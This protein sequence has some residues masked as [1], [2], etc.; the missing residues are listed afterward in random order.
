MTGTYRHI[1]HSL[2][3][4][5][6]PWALCAVLS[7]QGVLDAEM[8]QEPRAQCS[9]S[10]GQEFAEMDWNAA[11]DEPGRGNVLNAQPDSAIL[12]THAS[13]DVA[14]TDWQHDTAELHS[15][16]DWFDSV[17]VG[18]DDGFVIASPGQLSLQS[19]DSP[20]RMKLNG[21][22]QLRHSIFNSQGPNRDLNQIQLKRARI[23]FSG[24]AF[25]PDFS[26]F[27]QLD[28]RS[29]SGD[30]LR[31]LDY[32][33]T[34]DVGHDNWGYDKGTF[35]FKT[36]KYKMPF[37]MARHL[38]GREFEFTDRSMASIFFDVNRSLALGLYGRNDRL[39]I[40]LTWE[41]A[42]FNGL[43]TGGAET[44][45]SGTLDNNFAYSARVFCYPA[46]GDWGDASLADFA[47][48]TTPTTRFGAGCAFSTIDRLGDSEFDRVRVVDSGVTL[49]KLLP[50]TV[51][52]YSV[53]LYS[54]DASCKYHGLSTTA[55]YYFRH[56]SGFDG[57]ALPSLFDHGFW[58]QTGYFLIPE[59]LQ[60][61]ARWSRVTGNSGTLGAADQSSDELAG[62]LVWYIRGQ[63]AKATFDLTHLNG[64]CI[65]SS[66]LDIFPKDIGWL[67]RSQIQFA[68]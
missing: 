8:P 44:G 38:S 64:A 43:V 30:N 56:I 55:E 25:N 20:F 34:Y 33:L 45:S 5:C 39:G 67:F 2:S 1:R 47:H 3:A 60:L 13:A 6:T 61:L 52:A 24:N 7:I 63:H 40:P 21:W 29:T 9:I 28:G 4:S 58:L 19:S 66:V 18:Y 68:F 22:G 15:I 32:V 62:G 53:A 27:F 42:L 49:K 36:G 11:L 14:E 12:A 17:R 65:S 31:L 51:D 48:H 41:T 16:A 54:L 23:V 57:E 35:G 26:Y 50:T 37:T 59:K 46:G 10:S